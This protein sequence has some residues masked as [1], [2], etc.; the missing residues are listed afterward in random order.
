LWCHVEE[1]EE[2]EEGQALMMRMM[3]MVALA[4][5][6]R[7]AVTRLGKDNKEL[8]TAPLSVVLCITKGVWVRVSVSG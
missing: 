7:R 3:M 8:K 1:E 2:E 4:S 6:G 5:I